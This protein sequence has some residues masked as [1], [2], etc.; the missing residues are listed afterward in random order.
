LPCSTGD[1]PYGWDVRL[2]LTWEAFTIDLGYFDANFTKA[3]CN[4]YTDQTQGFRPPT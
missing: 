2:G 4:V 3:E 1:V